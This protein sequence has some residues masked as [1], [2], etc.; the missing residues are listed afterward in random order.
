MDFFE[1]VKISTRHLEL[2]SPA[3]PEKLW[4]IG[5]Y[6][7]LNAD[8]RVIDYGCGYGR[9]LA[10]WSEDFGISGIGVEIHSFISQRA[11]ER[12]EQS[13]L[14]DRIEIVCDNPVD[15]QSEPGAFDIS[16]CLGASFIWGGYQQALQ[17]MRE[18]LKEDG[19][20]VV[21][22]L[23]Y[24][25]ENV[26]PELVK[27]EGD[28]HTEYQLMGI[29]RSEG[30]DVEF[31]L[32]AS[33]DDWDRFVSAGW[34]GLLQWNDANPNH[35]ERQYVIDYLHKRQDMYFRYQREYEGWVFY[36]LNQRKY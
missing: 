34:Y 36:I 13:G 12:L 31:V 20:I 1:L 15:Y 33:R 26:P 6:L 5:Q 25:Q 17:R 8:K 23:Y 18:S 19:K 28:L 7:K 27:F 32:R 10:L 29:T 4:A 11:K 14:A 30:F 35:P 22:E 2:T 21:G 16:V 9:T 24:T 3:A